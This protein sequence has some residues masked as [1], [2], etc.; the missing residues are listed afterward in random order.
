MK[1]LAMMMGACCLNLAAMAETLSF[2]GTCDRNP[3][4]YRLGEEMTFTV[5]LVDIDDAK[6]SVA[7]RQ[8]VWKRQ[9]DDGKTEMGKATSDRP[10][11]S[12]STGTSRGR[13]RWSSSRTWAT[14][15]S[16]GRT[17]T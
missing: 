1:K 10:A 13:S 14:A 8:L 17:S 3:L 9:G 16:T 4:E 11:R 5:T 6:K 2:I 15:A 12:S 7:G